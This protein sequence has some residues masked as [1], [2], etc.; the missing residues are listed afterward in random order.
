MTLTRRLARPLLAATFISGG[1]EQLRDPHPETEIAEPVAPPVARALPVNLPEDPEQLV[2]IDG[3]MKLVGGLMLATGRLP[4]IAALV[5]ATNLIPT[6][7]AGHRFWEETDRH[8]RAAQQQHFL[9][10]LGLLGG[11]MLAAVDTEGRPS[12]GWRA[13]RAAHVAQE[14]A[15]EILPG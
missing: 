6:T 8:S 3:A 15:S 9:K 2:R 7:L 11:L 10:N 5:L 1:I 12:L 14:R 13:R 4:R